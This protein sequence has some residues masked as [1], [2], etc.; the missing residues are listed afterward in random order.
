MIDWSN[1]N[2]K[3]KTNHPLANC[4]LVKLI[5]HSLNIVGLTHADAGRHI[6]NITPS[7]EKETVQLIIKGL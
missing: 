5:R 7:D 4:Q 1:L 6:C 3:R 2:L